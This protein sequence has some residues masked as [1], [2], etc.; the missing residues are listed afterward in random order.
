MIQCF[1]A[2]TC[3]CLGDLTP[4]QSLTILD[5]ICYDDAYL[6]GNYHYANHTDTEKVG[7]V[8]I[9][10]KT[11][12]GVKKPDYPSLDDKCYCLEKFPGSDRRLKGE[13]VKN[14]FWHKMEVLSLPW[15]ED[16]FWPNTSMFKVES[17]KLFKFYS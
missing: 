5:M 16:L 3:E 17:L 6:E 15:H 9:A 10:N 4:E 1:P 11:R 2:D 14:G 7:L 12:C 13:G 8:L